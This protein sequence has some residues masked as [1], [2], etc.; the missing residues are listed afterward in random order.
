MCAPH[1]FPMLHGI[2][3]TL[4]TKHSQLVESIWHELE[5]EFGLKLASL[6]H[7]HLTYQVV[8]QYDLQRA[9]EILQGFAR[10]AAPFAIR[11]NG[12]GVFMGEAPGIF[13]SVVRPSALSKF[14][15]ILWEEISP[16]AQGIH[17]YHYDSQHWMPHI[18]LTPPHLPLE[19]VPEIIRY[20]TRYTFGWEIQIANITLALNIQTAHE[21]WKSYPLGERGE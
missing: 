1:H 10:R 4:D 21:M 15:S 14:H 3:S 6:L 18:S 11:T 2:A 8:E 5:R 20:L 16:I 12:L 9:D 7:P 19:L 17:D 13:V